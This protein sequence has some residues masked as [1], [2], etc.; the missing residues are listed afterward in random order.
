MLI[1]ARALV[2]G[3]GLCRKCGIKCSPRHDAA[4]N[5]AQYKS[6][7]SHYEHFTCL[8]NFYIAYCQLDLTQGQLN[9]KICNYI[10]PC[11]LSA[12]FCSNFVSFFT[13]CLI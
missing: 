5:A 13:N 7:K 4:A 8:H 12:S 1:C 10:D 11:I 3:S 9:V 2:L 6:I